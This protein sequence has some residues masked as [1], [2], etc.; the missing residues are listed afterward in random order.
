MRQNAMSNGVSVPPREGSAEARAIRM[1]EVQISTVIAA[2][3][4]PSARSDRR[5]E[6]AGSG[7][8]MGA[9]SRGRGAQAGAG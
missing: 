6:T 9:L 5:G 3:P 1:N 7:E 2:A 4:T 8:G